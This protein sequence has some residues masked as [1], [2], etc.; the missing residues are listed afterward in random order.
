MTFIEITRFPQDVSVFHMS[1]G[2]HCAPFSDPAQVEFQTV[3]ANH[4]YTMNC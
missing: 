3:L 1:G 4:E 2:S